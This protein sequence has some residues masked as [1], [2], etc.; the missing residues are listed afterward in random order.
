MYIYGRQ[1]TSKASH[2]DQYWRE[3]FQSAY[4]AGGGKGDCPFIKRKGKGLISWLKAEFDT[5]LLKATDG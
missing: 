5:Y 2:D 4:E 3:A 1:R